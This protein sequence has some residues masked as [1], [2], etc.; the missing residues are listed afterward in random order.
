MFMIP[1][2]RRRANAAS[3]LFLT[4]FLASTVAASALLLSAGPGRGAE[5]IQRVT[6]PAVAQLF[7]VVRPEYSGDRALATVAFV[8]QRWRWPGN[9]GFEESIDHVAEQLRAAGYVEEQGASPT[10]RLT[11]RVESRPMPGPAWEPIDA[12]LTI[13]G[14]S[15][16]VLRFATN[17]NMLAVNSASTSP[18]GV[19]A[20]VVSVGN[21]EGGA[22]DRVPL[23]GKIVFGDMSVGRLSSEARKRGA[24]GVLADAMPPYTKPEIHR[25]SIQFSSIQADT[26]AGT[27]GVLLSFDA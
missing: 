22:F 25:T 8:E 16:P 21:G 17:R 12:S 4:L 13:V 11:F 19:E 26:A 5:G 10:D 18:A 23:R 9:R 20:D 24:L 1:L 2:S 27:W 7:A 14:Q 6:P 15:A 3:S